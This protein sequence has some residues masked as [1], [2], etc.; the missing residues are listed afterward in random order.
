MSASIIARDRSV[1]AVRLADYVELTKPRIIVL[2]LI[3]AGAAACLAMPRGLDATAVMHAL[4]GTALVAASASIA[5]QWWERA[6]D[7]RMPRTANRPI[8]AGPG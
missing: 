6:N 4:F 2:E 7:A 8:P 3:V 5:N 1:I